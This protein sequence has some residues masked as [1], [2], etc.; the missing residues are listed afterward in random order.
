MRNVPDRNRGLDGGDVVGVGVVVFVVV[1]GQQ[2]GAVP[3]IPEPP[4]DL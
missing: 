4:Y 3:A 1:V 2:P